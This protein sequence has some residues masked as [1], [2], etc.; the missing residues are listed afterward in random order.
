MHVLVDKEDEGEVVKENFKRFQQ[1]YH[2]IWKETFG[3]AFS[4]TSDHFEITHDNATRRFLMSQ[5]NDNVYQ[6]IDK[7]LSV[8]SYDTDQK[9]HKAAMD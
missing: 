6:N 2:P 9:F 8:R 1:M 7:K 5:I 3:E 4:F